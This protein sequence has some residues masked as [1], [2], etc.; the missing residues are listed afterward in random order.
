MEGSEA[1]GVVEDAFVEVAAVNVE[2]L[3]LSLHGL[4]D[5]GMGV[6]DARD[7]VVEIEIAAAVSVVE[8]DPFAAHDVDGVLIESGDANA[9]QA[10]A[11]G[12]EI[13][14]RLFTHGRIVSGWRRGC[15]RGWLFASMITPSRRPEGT[16]L[17]HAIALNADFG[18]PHV[19]WIVRILPVSTPVRASLPPREG[20]REANRFGR[21][22]HALQG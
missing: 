19:V 21:G 4:D 2:G 12:E 1:L 22:L 11:A 17:R 18:R 7:V 20:S 16:A 14:D 10:L 9:E 15:K 5:V 6:A 8:P 3:G 13:G